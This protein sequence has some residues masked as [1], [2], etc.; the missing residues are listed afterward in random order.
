MSKPKF[1]H[2]YGKAVDSNDN[3][4]YVTIVGMLEQSRARNIVQ[5][6]MRVEAKP[7]KFVEGVLTYPYK[8][9]HRKLTLSLS[10][11]HPNDE[12][13][14]DYGVQLA[15]KRI[16]RGETLGSLETSNVTMLTED[17]IMGELMVKLN[18]VCQNIDEYI[19]E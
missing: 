19:G 15:K 1:Y 18:H 2:I 12:F 14:E 17:A 7:T 8:T 3:C 5:E 9:L 4:H 6:K 13:N 10:I 16:Q 11:C